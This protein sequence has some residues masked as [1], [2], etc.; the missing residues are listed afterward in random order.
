MGV[1]WGYP[2]GLKET[3]ARQLHAA[4]KGYHALFVRA[5]HVSEDL[6]RLCG[7]CR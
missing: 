1:S 4:D 3:P 7:C 2:A 6:F 5:Q